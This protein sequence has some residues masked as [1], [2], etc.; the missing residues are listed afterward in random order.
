MFWPKSGTPFSLG[1]AVPNALAKSCTLHGI[2]VGSAQTV[3]GVVVRGTQS[4]Q[5]FEGQDH[6]RQVFRTTV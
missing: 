4:L 5:V 2:R 6:R 3:L 1:G